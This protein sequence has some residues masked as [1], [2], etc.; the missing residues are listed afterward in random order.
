MPFTTTISKVFCYIRVSSEQQAEGA[1]LSEQRRV[2]EG[3]CQRKGLT[4]ATVFEDVET[5]AKAGRANFEVMLKKLRKGEAQGVIFHK[6]DRSSRN[7]RDW[8]TISDLMD[9]GVYV[10]FAAEGLESKD[11]SGRV[12]MDIL[13]SLAVHF[14]RN[15]KEEVK[16]GMRGRYHEGLLPRKAPIGYLDPPAGTPKSGRCLK[17]PDPERAPFIL[18]AHQ[19]FATGE[20]T[21]DRLKEEMTRRGFRTKSEKPLSISRIVD[22]LGNPFYAGFVRYEGQLFSGKHQAIVPLEL[23]KRVQALRHQKMHAM[24][25]KH[26][27]R[28]GQ[29]L[30]CGF[31]NR[32]LTPEIVKGHTYYRCHNRTHE[33]N[34]IREEMATGLIEYDLRRIKFSEAEKKAV[35]ASMEQ[36]TKGGDEAKRKERE[37]LVLMQNNA[38]SDRRAAA[39]AYLRGVMDEAIYKEMQDSLLMKEKDAADKLAG[40]KNV[41]PTQDLTEAVQMVELLFF[42]YVSA[43]QDGIAKQRAIIRSTCSN[44]TVK[45]KNVVVERRQWL[46]AIVDREIF[47]SGVPLREKVRTM[48]QFLRQWHIVLN[49]DQSW[50]ECWELVREVVQAV[51]TLY[52]PAHL[53]E[54]KRQLQTLTSKGAP[55]RHAGGQAIW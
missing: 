53:C 52:H 24:K 27:H 7:Y 2:I 28:L 12:A 49:E 21:L 26:E 36:M 32:L 50:R 34:S 6:V 10:A 1:S 31:C 42:A 38:A 15:L 54:K 48:E 22:V 29:L 16:K 44:L 8:L 40:M 3:F 14:I 11:T 33:S 35:S 9:A 18:Q 25:S 13:A 23:F 46:Q 17:T 51:T 5:A 39:A 43:G 47:S 20:Y 41:S 4:I 30:H 45:S 37:R 55:N 19:L